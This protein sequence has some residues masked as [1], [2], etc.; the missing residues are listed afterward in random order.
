NIVNG[1]VPPVVECPDGAT[2]EGEVDCYPDYD[3]L[4]NGGCNM[5]PENPAVFG[6]ISCGETICGTAGVFPY[7]PDLTYRDTDWYAFELTEA[8]TVTITG[9]AEFGLQ[10]LILDPSDD[11]QCVTVTAASDD[12]AP[13]ELITVSAVLDAGINY[14]WAGPSDWNLDWGCGSVYWI[15]MTCEAAPI[16]ACCDADL[17][18]V[19]DMNQFDCA[20]I[21]GGWFEGE[22][23]DDFEC[24]LFQQVGLATTGNIPDCGVSNYGVLGDY[25]TQL[26]TYT[27]NETVGANYEATFLMGDDATRAFS[28]Y[29]DG[30]TYV[31][32]PAGF[33]QMGDT[34][35]PTAEFNDGGVMGGVDVDYC[36]HG[37][38]DPTEAMDIFVH[39]YTLTNTSGADIPNFF[40]GLYFDWDIDATQPTITFDRARNLIIQEGGDGTNAMG[41]CLVNAD[42]VTLASLAAVV[43]QDYIYD[44]AGWLMADLYTIMSDGGDGVWDVAAA[45]MSSL[46]SV[47]PHTIAAGGGLVVQIA[48][49]GGATTADVQ[50]SADFLATMEVDPS[51]GDGGTCGD[52]VIGDYNGSASFNV[53]DIIAAFSKLKTGAPD[54]ALLCDCE[55]DGNIWAVAMDVNN[56]CAFNVADVIA[57]FSKLKTGAPVLVACEL[58]PPDG[59]SPRRGG[60]RPLIVPNLES[61]AK[62][63]TGSGME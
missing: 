37:Y 58:C 33:L 42:E 39:N 6:S 59:G 24:V 53:A 40:S 34:Y 21:N 60:D 45:D 61:K 11:D 9:E 54:A 13:F 52:Y 51:C 12:V 30:D 14:I 16:G 5:E 23:C 10:I 28:S 38:T 49:I 2:P 17:V 36:G 31:P 32:T 46:L 50:A 7:A 57:G 19:G 41:L 55:N 27:W 35:N 25:D 48:V 62:L 47:G 29:G 22:T 44:N 26:T 20:A 1:C 43:Q 3:D 15:E 18:C 8:S 63:S 4:T 56:S